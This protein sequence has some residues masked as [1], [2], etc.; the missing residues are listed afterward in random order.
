MNQMLRA[1]CKLE[2]NKF[3]NAIKTIGVLQTPKHK[4]KETQKKWSINHNAC[5]LVMNLII[6]N[7]KHEMWH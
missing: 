5:K 3:K 4:M 7:D 1:M 2:K 6:K